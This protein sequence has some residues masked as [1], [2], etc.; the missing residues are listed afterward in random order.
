MKTLSITSIIIKG[1]SIEIGFRTS[2]NL[3]KY[4][5]TTSFRVEYSEDVSKTPELLAILPFVCNVLPIVWITGAIL[6]VN[7][8]DDDFMIG[9]PDILNGYR[10]MFPSFKFEG[11]ICANKRVKNKIDRSHQIKSA[12]FFSG[13]VDAFA[14]LI[15][16]I[17]Q[18]PT[19]IT[20]RGS[21]IALDD[22]IGW[23]IVKNHVLRTSSDF[24]LDNVFV[25]TNFRTFINNK[26][27]DKLVVKSGDC[28]WHGFQHG[29]GLIGHAAPIV[30]KKKLSILYIASSFTKNSQGKLTCASDPTIDNNVKMAGCITIH[31]QYEYE[32]I[33][34]VRH[35]VEFVKETEIPIDLRVCWI[36]RGGRNCCKCEKCLRTMFEIFAFGE[37]PQKYGFNY[38]LKDLKKSQNRVLMG[39]NFI[40]KPLW[41]EIQMKI[42]TDMALTL[43]K[44][45]EWVRNIDFEK[46]RSK[47]GF[48]LLRACYAIQYMPIRIIHKLRDWIK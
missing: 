2:E 40:N 12:A 19:L 4:F 14:T 47:I 42:K 24:H 34:K 44:E 21:D 41:E 39:Y 32:R 17:D 8:I 16:H 29:V 30:W 38:S 23:R 45:I 20:L 6:E 7:E 9:Y 35:I 10:K 28:W 13:G 43:P 3:K 26:S 18:Y 31:D 1:K 33:E 11:T 25:R 36:T 46:E 37:D 22:E 27:L 48:K 5:S 15:A